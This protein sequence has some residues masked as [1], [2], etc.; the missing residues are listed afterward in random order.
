MSPVMIMLVKLINTWK[1][2][3]IGIDHFDPV[4]MTRYV[5][6]E[7]GRP[8]FESPV[9]GHFYNIETVFDDVIDDQFKRI[10]SD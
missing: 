9:L 8:P 10:G 1:I 2:A 7:H 3:I 4:I 5:E 6:T